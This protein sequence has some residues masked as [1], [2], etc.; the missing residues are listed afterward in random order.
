MANTSAELYRDPVPDLS[1]CDV[2]EILP[3]AHLDPPLRSVREL[4]TGQIQVS[5]VDPGSLTS[6]TDV[7]A[8]CSP[9]KALI[10]NYDC[11]IAKASVS[12]LVICPVI[13][14]SRFQQSDW[15]N[16]KRNRT[17]SLFF[18]PRYR[19]S[20][21]DSVAVLNQLTTVHR[22]MFSDLKR[23]VTLTTVGRLAFYAQFVRWLTRW[24]LRKMPCPSC[25]VEF[26]PTLALPVRSAE[27][28]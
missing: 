11:E 26:D 27:D 23:L 9:A 13:S 2:V 24:E 15:G 22:V 19:V 18:L 25:N 6:E 14:L 7:V 17:A 1:Q 10:I 4:P 12:R 16:V 3:H 8:G 21:E 5:E 20:L 28:Q